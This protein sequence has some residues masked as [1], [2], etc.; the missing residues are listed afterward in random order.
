[1]DTLAVTGGGS[2]STSGTSI[3]AGSGAPVGY[4]APPFILNIEPGTSNFELVLVNSGAGT[5]A[6]PW[7]ITRAA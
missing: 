3:Y 7:I 2:L 4:P 1:M 6:S 5:A